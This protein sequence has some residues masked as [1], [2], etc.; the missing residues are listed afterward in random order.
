M[1]T[2]VSVG[3]TGCDGSRVVFVP[4]SDG[5][6]R[7]GPDVRGHV[8]YWNGNSWEL[9]S[10]KVL[11]PEGWYAGSIDGDVEESNNSRPAAVDN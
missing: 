6:I 11:L 7:L 3:L 10:K 1:L 2:L 9:S 4:E 5:L 8:Y